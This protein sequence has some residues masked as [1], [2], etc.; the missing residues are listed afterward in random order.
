MRL[1]G[2]QIYTEMIEI[3]ASNASFAHLSY[4]IASQSER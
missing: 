1:P 2:M 4:N 3:E